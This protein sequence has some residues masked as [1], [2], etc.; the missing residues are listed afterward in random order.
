MNSIGVLTSGGDAPGMNAAVRAVVRKALFHG[1]KVYG[2]ER[3]YAGLIN[4]EIKEMSLGSVGDII[5]RGGTVLKTAR[6]LEFKT[7]EGRLRAFQ[8]LKNHGIEGLVVIGGDGSFQGALKLYEEFGVKVVGIPATI[9]NDIYGTDYS[10]GFDTTVNTVVDAINKIRDTAFSHERTFIVEVMGRNAGFIALEAGIA[11]GAESIIIP[12]IPY[13]IE[14]ICQKLIKSH[15]RGKLHSIII[16]AEGAGSG[17]KLGEVIKEKTGFETRVTI[18]GHI[19]RGGSPS[20]FDRI[21]ASRMGAMAVDALRE[22]ISQGVMVAFEKGEYVL[23]P[24]E[25][26]F[27][28]KKQ[29]DLEYYRLADILSI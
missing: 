22:G 20:A 23:K 26:A 15:Q 16:I 9:D 11:G 4:N 17:I 21:L 24:L 3:G 6:S 1:I 14:E 7:Y 5:Q 27:S 28:G 13:S 18:L 19:Q 8:N 25:T 2:I 10:I 12:E 29:I